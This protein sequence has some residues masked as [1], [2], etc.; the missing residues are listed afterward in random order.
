MKRLVVL[1]FLALG[2]FA[3]QGCGK[4]SSTAAPSTPTN[5]TD[6]TNP[7]TPTTPPTTDTTLS[8]ASLGTLVDLGDYLNAPGEEWF[9]SN[10]MDVDTA[11]QIIGESPGNN[12]ILYEP[13][14]TSVLYGIPSP[15]SGMPN[16][17]GV[18]YD[19]FYNQKANGG[20]NPFVAYEVLK[21][22]NL[23]S[24]TARIIGNAYAGVSDSRGFV[25][26]WDSVTKS[27]VSYTDL[28]PP[29]FINN[30]G[31]REVGA[32]SHVVDINANG[33]VLLTAVSPDGS[34][35]AYYW[36]GSSMAS[37]SDLLDDG[38]NPI[39]TFSVPVLVQVPSIL[40]AD[41]AEA[42]ALNDTGQAVTFSLDEG[43][44]FDFN[45]GGWAALGM[46]PGATN[47][48]PVAIN[49]SKH[50]VGVSGN[51][52]FFWAGGVM[53]PISNPSGAAIEIVGMN[54]NDLVVGNS[55]GQA[56]VWYLDPTT[57][58]G[59]FSPIGTL[60]GT[61][62]TAVGINDRGEVIGY[63]TTG[64]VYTEGNVT[65][66]VVHGFVWK[67]KVMY[68]LGAHSPPNY[69]YPFNPDFY[70]SKATAISNPTDPTVQTTVTGISYSI[71]G[72]SRGF[73]IPLPLTF[74]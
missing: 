43:V 68:D 7:T 1:L 26:D 52:G 55:D 5:P 47:S 56:F 67:A 14:D 40:R 61:T 70:F 50:I 32:Y 12:L 20:S 27:F 19:D 60:G 31:A 15:A 13:T 44:Y 42:V 28:T 3:L 33:A 25:A 11:G 74:P 69:A 63:S 24:T 49:N 53:Y 17:F 57:Q 38:G 22:V 46:L 54:N 4:S 62:S 58:K 29:N 9:L 71:N 6:P 37:V 35:R 30:S 21:I 39:P 73:T 48:T 59:V 10:T 18:F 2:L 34:N 45:I 23:S 51:E 8:T 65:A 36:D 66:D 64:N 41:G 72:H 16:G